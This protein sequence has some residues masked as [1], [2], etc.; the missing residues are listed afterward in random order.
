L[1][2]PMLPHGLEDASIALSF[3]NKLGFF[4]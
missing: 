2:A 3:F 4:V 1:L